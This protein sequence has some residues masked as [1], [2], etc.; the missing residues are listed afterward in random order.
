MIS[1]DRNQIRSFFREAWQKH[2]A[3]SPVSSMEAIVID[4]VA[5]H[6]EYHALLEDPH[7]DLKREYF[8]EHGAANP[9]LHMGLHVA[10]REQLGAD[11]PRALRPVYQQLVT[12]FGSAHEAEHQVIECIAESLAE[13]QRSGTPV[14]DH[15]YVDCLQRLL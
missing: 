12:R 9:F 10:L 2:R 14:S 15:Q 1:S 8:P 4:V 5:A 13:A 11:R 6:P 3:G 7:M